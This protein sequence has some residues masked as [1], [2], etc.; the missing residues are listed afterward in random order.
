LNEE[1]GGFATTLLDR[2]DEQGFLGFRAY[3][4]AWRVG[5]EALQKARKSLPAG[6]QSVFGLSNIL[7]LLNGLL[8][9]RHSEFSPGDLDNIERFVHGLDEHPFRIPEKLAAV[10]A[11]RLSAALEQW[12]K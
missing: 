12:V 6:E 8:N 1:S 3:R 5:N 9:Y 4:G 11:T 10:R 2:L 7:M